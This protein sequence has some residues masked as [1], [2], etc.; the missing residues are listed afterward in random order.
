MDNVLL[1]QE[2]SRLGGNVYFSRP[3][4][5]TEGIT[6]PPLC[7]KKWQTTCSLAL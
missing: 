6:A 2:E 5:E 1:K 4:C 7:F 3:S